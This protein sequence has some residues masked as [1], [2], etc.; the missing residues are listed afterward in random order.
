MPPLLIT[1]VKKGSQTS[2]YAMCN[3]IQQGIE[4]TTQI[5][6]SSPIEGN[7]GI[8]E[9]KGIHNFSSFNHYPSV[10]ILTNIIIRHGQE[11]LTSN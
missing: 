5:N 11:N 3:K 6:P 8:N 4:G 10:G 2:Q 7:F 1:H 9:E